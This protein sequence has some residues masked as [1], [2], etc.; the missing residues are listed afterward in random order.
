MILLLE[1][2]TCIGGVRRA[3]GVVC[4]SKGLQPATAITQTLPPPLFPTI[5][6]SSDAETE[7]ENEQAT[8][9]PL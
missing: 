5:F 6:I 8:A 3:S 2:Q 7:I 4:L 9:G 1:G